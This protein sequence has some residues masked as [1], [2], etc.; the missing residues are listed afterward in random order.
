L[1]IF[2][3]LIVKIFSSSEAG[4]FISDS[5]E[6]GIFLTENPF[7]KPFFVLVNAASFTVVEIFS[8]QAGRYRVFRKRAKLFNAA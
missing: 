4:I 5:E 1:A 6:E 8:R 2:C 3:Y 7:R